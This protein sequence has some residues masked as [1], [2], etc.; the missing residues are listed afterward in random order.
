MAAA[1]RQTQ[2]A[3]QVKRRVVWVGRHEGPVDGMAGSRF[4]IA[5]EGEQV[6]DVNAVTRN[7]RVAYELALIISYPE[8]NF[9]SG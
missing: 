1:V 9:P 4:G 3:T 7:I 8:L 2:E 6:E 5:D